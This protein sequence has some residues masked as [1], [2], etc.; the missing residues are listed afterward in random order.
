MPDF[1]TI[2]TAFGLAAMSSAESSGT[3]VSL[4]HIAVGDSGGVEVEPYEMQT[5]LVNEV[6]R[7]EVSAVYRSSVDPRKF[8]AEIV[9]PASAPSFVM[10][11]ACII[12]ESGQMFV[13]GNLP[14]TTKPS[15]AVPDTVLRIEFLAL[16]PATVELLGKLVTVPPGRKTIYRMG[17]DVASD[18]QYWLSWTGIVHAIRGFSSDDTTE[19]TFYTGDGTPK[20]TNNI[21]GLASAPY[22][23]TS[24]PIGIPAPATAL[25]AVK[26]AGSW[27][28]DVE[29]YFYTYTYVSDWGWESAPAQVSAQLDRESD[30]TT[31]LSAFAA[32]PAGNYGINRIRIYRTQ[33]GASGA[34]EFFFLREIAYGTTSTT[35]DNRTLG[36]V[37]P[38]T[39][40]IPA[41]DDLHHLTA[42]WNGMAAG[43]AENGVRFCEPYAAYAWPIQ[44]EILPPDSKPVALG[45]AGQNLLVL[46]TGRPHLV[47][48]TSPDSMDET[49]LEFSQACVA[50]ES[51]AS[52]GAG[53]A[54]ASGDGLCW[55][56]P[57]T[58]PRILTAGI[59]TRDDWQ[60]LRPSTIIGQMYEG[61]YLGSY[62]DGSGRKAF[63]IDPANPTGLYFLDAGYESMHF[64]ELQ[65]Q[66]YILNG[67]N[68]Q[69]WDAGAAFMTARARS[70]QFRAPAPVN[71]GAAEV[72]AD[73]YPVTF[74]VFAD[75]A[76]KHTQNVTSRNPF[77]LP[78]GF[79]ALDWQFEVE[80]TGA[81]QG[82]SVATSMRE[83][84]QT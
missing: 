50:P 25:T 49:P 77:H 6:F 4:T 20:V 83:L 61:L 68:V 31:T 36:E 80:T 23:T 45:V 8:T 5:A 3:P 2:H 75:G 27:T 69:R 40:W 19:Q 43:I 42:L 35:D 73:T 17:R 51:V 7:A 32:A 13:V 71:F 41:P 10:R 74:R 55:W 48:G 16:S 57:G 29:T 72:V 65:D 38:T 79:M 30:A 12:D 37:L 58:G 63:L 11:E 76:L 28:G 21:I 52:M 53:V 59:M 82:C 56:G 44:Y 34:T 81:V 39:T 22:P 18:S 26:N 54:W 62:D 78:S 9:I 15:G 84:S 14:A 64:D 47:S 1:R 33:T 70:K 60:A 67:T 24:R 46:T 66:L